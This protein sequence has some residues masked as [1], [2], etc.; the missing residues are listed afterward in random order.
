MMIQKPMILPAMMKRKYYL[1]IG[2]K[3]P[4]KTICKPAYI[5]LALLMLSTNASTNATKHQM[6]SKKPP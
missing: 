4:N 3:N 5:S 2:N 6:V 1:N